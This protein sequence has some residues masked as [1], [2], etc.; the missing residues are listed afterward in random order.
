M[1]LLTLM[2]FVVIFSV[3]YLSL[4]VRLDQQKTHRHL[5]CGGGGGGGGGGAVSW[6]VFPV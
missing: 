4:K 6:G 5:P 1:F 2:G 3:S